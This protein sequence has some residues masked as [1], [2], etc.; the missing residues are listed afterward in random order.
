LKLSNCGIDYQWA[1]SDPVPYKL[2]YVLP[3]SA[4]AG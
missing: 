2:V 4:T 3:Y 1:L